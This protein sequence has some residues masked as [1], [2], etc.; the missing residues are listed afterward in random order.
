M[1]LK[2]ILFD[3]GYK[4]YKRCAKLA[5]KVL[6]LESEFSKLTDEELA[7]KTE[8]F[9]VELKNGK[10]L[11][12]ILVPAYATVREMAYRVTGM[13]AFFVQVAGAIAIH[14]GNIAEMKTGEGKT[15]TGVFPAYLNALSGDGVHIVTVNEYLAGREANGIIGDIYRKLGLT[16][17]LNLRELNYQEKRAVYSCDV[18]YS[19]NSELGFD[20]L[21]DN[22]VSNYEQVT[23]VKGL[24]YAIIDEV[25]SILIDDARTPLIISGGEKEDKGLYELADKFVKSLKEDDYSIDIESKTI[26][27]TPEGITKAEKFFNV[28]ADEGGLYDGNH[29]DVV[30][31]INNA[32]KAVYI[33]ANG[34]EYVV[35]DDHKEVLIVDQST[36]RILKG[37][38]FSEGLHQALEAKEGVE[39][40]KE[41][42]TVATITYQNFFR[43]YN[44]LSGMT[45]TAKTEEEE[46]RDIYN[47]YVVEVPT[48][49]PVIRI[50]APDLIFISPE[51]KFR[52]LVEDIKERHAKGQPILVGTAN[53][54]TSELVSKMLE[55]EGLKHEVLNAKNN[56]REAEIVSHA[57]ELGAITISTN[58][59]GRGTDIKLGP[60][61]AELGGLAVL[62]TERFQARRIDNQLRGRAG[63]QGDP[64]YSRFFLSTE[65]ELLIRFGGDQF[66]MRLASIIRMMSDGDETKPLESRML[67]RMITMAQTKIEGINYDS[68]KNVLK[69][70]DVIRRQRETFY[71]ERQ[72]VVKAEKLDEVLHSIM[73]IAVSNKVEEFMESKEEFDDEKLVRLFNEKL[74][75]DPIID[76]NIVKSFDDD[77]DIINYIYEQAR[78]TFDNRMIEFGDNL[79]ASVPD[80]VLVQDPDFVEKN[81]MML[82]KRIILPILDK[83]WREHIDDMDS[84][85]QGVYLQ[86]YAQSNPLEIYQREGYQKFENLNRR[87]NEQIFIT[88]MHARVR[89]DRA[90]ERKE[91]ELK[92]LSTNQDLSRVRQQQPAQNPFVNVGP[93]DA[94]PC[95]SGK[96]FKFCHGLK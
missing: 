45:G 27:L 88:A 41:A 89:F 85:R 93:N 19:T 50:D 47:M 78:K 75:G 61:V 80:D 9:R 64:G 13:K 49:R 96:K 4:E 70:D 69:Y 60:G 34:K 84:F 72:Q 81:K 82:I 36:G 3:S 66:K 90:P 29:I 11:D 37:R 94:C 53:V 5:E 31:R 95:G 86:Q 6:A 20:Y 74:I 92:G 40:K 42:I 7:N 43:M 25:D 91:D 54:E 8:E 57:G 44:K 10:T 46:F 26:A 55:K 35:S 52:A 59:A 63:R 67:Q 56:A 30:H 87:M 17:G 38:Q 65:D 18:I 79:K 71:A 15:L 83:N 14:G 51:F 58:M 16:V 68:R 33:F 39:I 1:G 48:N 23:Q 62:A 21:R 12:D 2:K 77:G 22:M 24:N 32:L 76:I 28:K 73:K